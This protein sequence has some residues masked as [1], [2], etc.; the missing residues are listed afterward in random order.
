I[1]GE[2]G[3][4]VVYLAE[5]SH[6]RRLV[7][8]KV[9][10]A[11]LAGPR[12]LRRFEY[13]A[14]LLARLEHPG[15]ARIYEAGAIDIGAGLQPFFAME[16]VEGLPL[17]RFADAHDLNVRDRLRLLAEICDAVHH[18]HQKG[19]IHRDLKPA[20]I[21]V[22][23]S[24]RPRI[25]D[26]GVARAVDEDAPQATLQTDI[27][28][29]VGTLPYMSPEQLT[30]DSRD[31][32]IRA[33][34]Y[35]LGVIAYQLLTGR[36]PHDLSR[37]TVAEAARI[38]CEDRVA[39][40][41]SSDANLRGDIETIVLKAME[42]DRDR[43]YPSASDL[44]AD[45][46]AFLEDRPISARPPSRIYAMRK[47][48]RRNRALVGG[49]AGVFIALVLGVV[50]SSY[51]F[52]QATTARHLAEAEAERAR[53][54]EEVATAARDEA[55][56]E[57]ARANAIKSF[58]IDDMLGAAD[59]EQNA[60]R[61]LT[62]R[63]ALDAAAQHVEHAFDEQP[64]VNVELRTTIGRI[65]GS[66]GHYDQAADQYRQALARARADL[67]ED[68][69]ETIA[70]LRSLALTRRDV[71]DA[72]GALAD[73]DQVIERTKRAWG[74][75]HLY[76]A[77]AATDKAS[78]LV[79]LGRYEEAID[80]Y[81]E[82]LPRIIDFY[83][84][85]HR[86]VLIAR[87]NLATSLGNLGR[88]QEAVEQLRELFALR[89]DTLG[90]RHPDTLSSMN[91]IATNLVE[92]ARYDEAEPMLR[93]VIAL[94]AE[95]LGEAHPTTINSRLNL[96]HMLI[97]L[98]RLDEAEPILRESLAAL[99]RTLGL[100]HPTS[101][102]TLN[103]LAY[104]LEDLGQLDQA[105]AMHRDALMRWERIGADHPNALIA[106]NN[107]AMVLDRQGEYDEAAQIYDRL[108]EAA[109]RLFPAGHLYIAIFQNNQGAALTALKRFDDAEAALRASHDVL[110]ATLGPEHDRV[111]KAQRRLEDLDA[112]RL[113]Q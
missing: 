87:H 18:A 34:V 29:I 112:A 33:D 39:P 70:A 105:E 44:A 93:E 27:G 48:T 103:H 104:L 31:L 35:T 108:L 66:L 90:P 52:A 23:D 106:M 60:D 89:L 51:G 26:F 54:A 55:R 88:Q 62:V 12:L 45:L 75:D 15:V 96:C 2:G 80:L 85:S 71:G 9:I 91:N 10:R 102:T 28:Q 43:R 86:Y 68:E 65:Y 47:F 32:D 36:L 94:R 110:L 61:E 42:R 74:V 83:G 59:P 100:D 113:A 24:G 1:L 3:M 97:T 4:G 109:R 46:R 98:G 99:D 20:N 82:A 72:E 79:S 77:E 37:K 40:L 13:E 14:Q 107:L 49:V 5:Q 17:D 111:K 73:I 25:L 41:R 76:A 53:D 21:L 16:Y 84:D 56:R 67:G 69:P 19:V 30:G 58:L 50:A 64:L 11:G 78:I 101:L 6:P 81:H 8:L 63:E 92:L 38:I 7:A 22:D 57:A 95:S